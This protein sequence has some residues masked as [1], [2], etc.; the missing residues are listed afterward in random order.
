MTRT[1]WLAAAIAAAA[2]VTVISAG[3]TALA[4]GQASHGNYHGG[5]RVQGALTPS[6][7]GTNYRGPAR[8]AVRPAAIH[9]SNRLAANTPRGNG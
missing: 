6:A 4:S 2:A 1:R 5:S 7:H 9:G 8:T 3:A